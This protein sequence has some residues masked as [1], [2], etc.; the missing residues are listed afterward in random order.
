MLTPKVIFAILIGVAVI[1][2]VLLAFQQWIFGGIVTAVGLVA[3]YLW[4]R[5]YQILR[6]GEAMQKGDLDKADEYLKVISNP[7][8]LNDYSKTYYYFFRGMVDIQRGQYKE[9]RSALKRSLE[10]GSFR[11]IDEKAAAM[12]ALAQLDLRSRNR[13]GAKRLLQEARDLDPAEE[14]RQQIKT[15]AKQAQIR[16][17]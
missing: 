5:L 1:G 8:K 15:I 2:L 13:Q 11:A 6:V 9:S 17:T 10:V 14:I 16:L 3:V 7:E 12:L 4:W